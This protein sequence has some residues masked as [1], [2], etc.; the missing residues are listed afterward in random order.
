MAHID[1][2]D[3]YNFHIDIID[4]QHIGILNLI[5]QLD[6]A[7]GSRCREKVGPVL[8]EIVAAI[9]SHF[10]FEEELMSASGYG[11]LGA[12]KKLHDRFIGRLVDFAQRYDSGECIIEEFHPFLQVWFGRHMEE[13]KDF[14]LN[15]AAEMNAPQKRKKGWFGRTFGGGD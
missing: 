4:E 8:N 5:N 7:V 6:D 15:A 9:T 13:D 10:E 12:H 2:L 1:W 14:C 11:H 3:S